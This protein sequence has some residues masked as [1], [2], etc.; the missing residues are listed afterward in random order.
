MFLLCCGATLLNPY[1]VRLYAA[2]VQ[3]LGQKELWDVISELGAMPFRRVA[4]WTVLAAALAGAAAIAWAPYTHG[5]RPVRLLLVILFPLALYLSFRSMRD[6]WLVLVVALALVGGM[7]RGLSLEATRLTAGARWA[8]AAVLALLAA[9]GLSALDET[10]LRAEVAER[11]PVRALTFL[12][13]HPCDGPLYNTFNWGGFLI[14][15]FP[16]QPVSIDGRTPV[17]GAARILRGA[18]V[19]HGNEGWQSDPDIKAARLFILP[20]KD[21][22]TSLLRLDTRFEIA[23]EDNVAVVFVRSNPGNKKSPSGS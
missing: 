4:D 21:A 2:A 1:H 11:F 3:L 23:Y 12:E 22:V 8:V 18:N 6:Q 20:R 15:R 5:R 7:S 16:Q 10:R 17:H 19:Q 13:H 14:D 9:A